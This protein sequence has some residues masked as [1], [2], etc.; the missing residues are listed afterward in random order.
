MDQNDQ[1]P[2]RERDYH[3]FF[4]LKIFEDIVNKSLYNL[5]KIK[6]KDT[7]HSQ[8]V[9]N[10]LLKL[11]IEYDHLRIVKM[12][13][14]L[15]SQPGF[16]DIYSLIW[17]KDVKLIEYMLNHG[18]EPRRRDREGSILT[19]VVLAKNYKV[20]KLFL[21]YIPNHE[22]DYTILDQAAA[23]G[24]VQIVKYIVTHLPNDR[25]LF[26]S[27]SIAIAIKEN[28]TN[29]MKI[30][31]RSVD[32]SRRIASL[33]RRVATLYDFEREND[34]EMLKI[35]IDVGIN[36]ND[37]RSSLL[38]HIIWRA[39]DGKYYKDQPDVYD[40]L[41]R[42]IEDKIKLLFTYG[43]QVNVH[44]D[45]FSP[46]FLYEIEYLPLKVAVSTGEP[47]IVKVVLDAGADVNAVND[48]ALSVALDEANANSGKN[49]LIY[50][51]YVEIIKMLLENGAKI[52]DKIYNV[53][54]KFDQQVY[55][56][57]ESYY[58]INLIADD[59]YQAISQNQ[60]STVISL[61]TK[62]P[63][64]DY[65]RLINMTITDPQILSILNTYI[66][67]QNEALYQAITAGNMKAVDKLLRAGMS[68]NFDRLIPITTLDSKIVYILNEHMYNMNEKLMRI[69]RNG[70]EKFIKQNGVVTRVIENGNI[71]AI[72]RILDSGILIDIVKLSTVVILNPEIANL[73]NTYNSKKNDILYKAIMYGNVVVVKQV[74]DS[75][76][77][78]DFT[79]LGQ[80]RIPNVEILD[81]LNSQ[82]RRQHI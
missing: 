79:K 18:I 32:W 21:D 14:L 70:N 51:N 59:V 80:L 76:I 26:N 19:D 17:T 6:I 13:N 27:G 24:N 50:N 39:V 54:K 37:E 58:K 9:L 52:N 67:S 60:T 3:S 44:I 55:H 78:L 53:Q 5:F 66:K 20:F 46:N 73:L 35:L 22:F 42:K 34:I 65:N 56:I 1:K 48:L 16:R 75:G 38:R 40:K 30:L 82:L 64:L 43:A 29:I 47:R 10:Q 28:R 31:I 2:N 25:V 7:I 71:M 33:S 41:I 45:K 12:L 68:I 72:K 23:A 63:I 15:G 61:L 62:S 4:N 77:I 49:L 81:L 57:L 8:R 74:L 11:A 69:I 36:V